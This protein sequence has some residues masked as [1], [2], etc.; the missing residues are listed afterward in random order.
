MF[1]TIHSVI[2]CSIPYILMRWF[3]FIVAI[4]SWWYWMLASTAGT[5][6]ICIKIIVFSNYLFLLGTPWI[7]GACKWNVFYAFEAH[8]WWRFICRFLKHI[9]NLDPVIWPIGFVIP[10]SRLNALDA[11]VNTIVV[12]EELAVLEG[13]TKK[14]VYDF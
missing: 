13:P 11:Y 6:G 9:S 7:K 8:W 1:L 2:V 4:G 5:F 10:S 12:I 3:F 14:L